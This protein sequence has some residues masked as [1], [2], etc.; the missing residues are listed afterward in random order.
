[1]KIKN[2]VELVKCIVPEP[3]VI[4]VHNARM[5]KEIIR[6]SVTNIVI[7]KVEREKFN[8]SDIDNIVEM[9]INMAKERG[10]SIVKS[11]ANVLYK[12]LGLKNVIGEVKLSYF[13]NPTI[14]EIKVMDFKNWK[15]IGTGIVYEYSNTCIRSNGARSWG[16]LNALYNGTVPLEIVVKE[17]RN[18]VWE[19]VDN[20][21]IFIEFFLWYDNVKHIHNDEQNYKT[22]SEFEISVD[23]IAV[24]FLYNLYFKVNSASTF[25]MNLITSELNDILD[26]RLNNTFIVRDTGRLWEIFHR[27]M[28]YNGGYRVLVRSDLI[29]KIERR[30][31]DRIIISVNRVTRRKEYSENNWRIANRLLKIYPDIDKEWIMSY[32]NDNGRCYYCGEYYGNDNLYTC[33][34]SGH[35]HCDECCNDRHPLCENCNERYSNDFTIYC[36]ICEM[37][38]C[39]DCYRR[40]HFYCS[41]CSDFY[42]VDIVKIEYCEK[43]S[44]NHCMGCFEECNAKQCN[45]EQCQ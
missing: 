1:M 9:S 34:V 42:E 31:N 37:L 6:D 27:D 2:A 41:K 20:G 15:Y 3:I 8:Y 18:K 30:N 14:I 40:L 22:G 12:V 4:D 32:E 44:E 28:Y 39:E 19:V 43:C 10:M 35:L 7:E 21:R 11:I 29:E 26:K 17:L 5:Y 36:D 24:I 25:V 38:Y 16:F 33:N 23:D 13:A 45:A